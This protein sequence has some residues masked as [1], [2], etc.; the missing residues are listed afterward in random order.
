[1]ND[2]MGEKKRTKKINKKMLVLSIVIL[3]LIIGI[4]TT[5]LLY[6]KNEDFRNWADK[7]ILRKEITE[8]DAINIEIRRKQ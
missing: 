6:I 3:I 5:I 2:L 1:M 7:Y 4:I 8:D